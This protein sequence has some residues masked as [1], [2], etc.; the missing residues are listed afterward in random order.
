MPKPSVA[1]WSAKPTIRTGDRRAGWSLGSHPALERR[2]SRGAGGETGSEQ[3]DQPDRLADALLAVL[4]RFDRLLDDLEPVLEDVDEQEGEHTD[5]EH[6][7]R[8]P[9]TVAHDLEPRER[10]AEVDREARQG[11]EQDCFSEGQR[12]VRL[13]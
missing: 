2:Q 4:E 6:R 9:A 8:H 12:L 11:S 5:S 1:L 13:A 10:Q 3:R 7:Q